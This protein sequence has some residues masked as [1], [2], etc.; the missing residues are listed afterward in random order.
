MLTYLI[1]GLIIFATFWFMEF[2]AWF[3]HKYVMHGFLWFLHHDHHDHSTKP[4]FEKNDLF[5]VF[6]AIP[7]WLFMMYGVIDGWDY[8]FYVGTGILLYGI[9]YFLAHEV[10]VHQRI[11]W[12]TKSDNAYIN[13][14]RRA[15]KIHHKHLGKENGENFGFLIVP[16][17]Y[18]KKSS[19]Q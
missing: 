3:T 9:A 18:F 15:H 16:S 6:F 11:K 19:N 7:S 13:A 2:V 1:N 10:I 17:K 5:A 12:F 14:L 4:P 8:K